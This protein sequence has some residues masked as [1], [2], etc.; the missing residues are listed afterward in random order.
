MINRTRKSSVVLCGLFMLPTSSKY[1][2]AEPTRSAAFRPG[3]DV[4]L[5]QATTEE[6]YPQAVIVTADENTLD[7]TLG[8]EVE[9]QHAQVRKNLPP[10][11]VKG[12]LRADG[13]IEGEIPAKGLGL[14]H[15]AYIP[16]N[17]DGSASLEAVNQTIA[18]LDSNRAQAKAEKETARAAKKAAPKAA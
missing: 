9:T 16:A 18:L 5:L 2:M 15:W 14:A 6:G 3:Q 17:A 11:F 7:W 12:I 1:H 10:R 8:M 13:T 4:F